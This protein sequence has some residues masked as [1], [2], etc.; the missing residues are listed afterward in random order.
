MRQ[1]R[2]D[3]L[4]KSS[5]SAAG[6]GLIIPDFS[7][8]RKIS[9][10]E[11]VN[12]GLIG[13]RNKGY[14]ILSHMMETGQVNC[15]GICDVDRNILEKR[16]EDVKK[17]FGQIPKGYGDFR[18]LLEDD[19]IDA[20]IIG[21]PDH[22]HCL[23][24]VLACQAGKDVYVEKPLAN[25]IEE[26]NL[27]L[28]AARKYN[29]VVQ[30]GQQQRSGE[31]WNS[32]MAHIHSGGIGV[33]KRVNVWANFPYGMGASK[34]PNETIPKGLEYDFWLGPASKRTYNPNRVHGNW[35]HFW[36]YGGGLMTD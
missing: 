15:L 5:A 31:V 32:A 21:T 23:I 20:V 12:I 9:P 16:I 29:R 18:R 19:A 34:V 28:A 33:I 4:K 6:L 24:M 2:R 25:S 30:V 11:K 27:M 8:F 26:C 7:F 14:N 36:D 3:F 1:S 35:R 13:A 22:W 10:N 17:S